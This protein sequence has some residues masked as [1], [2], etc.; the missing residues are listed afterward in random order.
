VFL[1][2]HAHW[3][4]V[5][6]QTARALLC[7][8]LIDLMA[9][10]TSNALQQEPAHRTPAAQP[11][12]T[13]HIYNLYPCLFQVRLED[14]G[15]LLALMIVGHRLKRGRAHSPWFV[16]HPVFFLL[17]RLIAHAPLAPESYQ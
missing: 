9:P 15:G 1:T 13:R 8:L 3:L 11:P 16:P 7:M 12:S 4:I 6:L 17:P 14:F 5:F 2:S 10:L